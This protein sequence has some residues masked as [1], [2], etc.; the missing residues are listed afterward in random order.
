[1]P[2]YNVV[3]ALV[4]REGKVLAARRGAS[5][6]E[7]VA[8]KFEFVGGKIEPGETEEEALMRELREELCVSARILGHFRTVEHA[9]PDFSVRLAVYAVEFLS[10]FHRI[11][12]EEFRWISV[13]QLDPDEWAPADA[14]IVLA[15]RR[16][17]TV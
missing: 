5:K 16:G 11:E 6:Y 3:G 15:L 7:Y 1:M 10:E 17:E 12:H 14:P 13:A 2:H 4:M 9:Y 8:H